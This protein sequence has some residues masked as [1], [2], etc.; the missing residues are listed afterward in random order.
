MIDSNSNT[1]WCKS[2][3]ECIVLVKNI[4]A[5]FCSSYP[6]SVRQYQYSHQ[7]QCQL[8][9]IFFACTVKHNFI[10]S[11]RNTG[12]SVK[13]SFTRTVPLPK[14]CDLWYTQLDFNLYYIIHVGEKSADIMIFSKSRGNETFG[15]LKR[16]NHALLR[17][18]T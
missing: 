17:I 14:D 2:C 5:Y 13:R 9:I 12:H 15:P 11:D 8:Y 18:P 6:Y 3:N 7:S 4:L 10:G 16:T 1:K